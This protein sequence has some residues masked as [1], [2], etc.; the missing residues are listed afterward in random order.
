M[1]VRRMRRMAER[2]AR[3]GGGV[4]RES[5]RAGG[6]PPALFVRLAFP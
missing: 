4:N 2:L 1:A 3:R 5:K 6:Y